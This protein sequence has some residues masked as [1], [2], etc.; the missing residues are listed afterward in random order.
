MFPLA[1]INHDTM[2]NT[3]TAL[4]KYA[5][6]YRRVSTEEQ[7][8]EGR[9]SLDTQ[10]RVCTKAVE[11]SEFEVAE[12][13]LYS[14]EGKSATT[15]NRPALQDLLL[16][17]GDDKSIGAVFVQ[18]TDRLARNA[19]DHLT[20]KLMFKK[21]G[22]QLVSVSQ[23]GLED[24]PEGNFMDLVIAGVNQFQS[25]I[26][27]RKS[28]KSMDERFRNGWYPT[29]AP[30]GYLNVPD[31]KNPDKKII[32]IDPVRGSLVKEMLTLYATGNHSLLEVRDFMYKKGLVNQIGNCLPRS[33]VAWIIDNPF[34]WGEMTWGG[35]TGIGKHEPLISKEL[36]KKCQAVKA[37]H[38]R[39]TC[40]RRKHN[41]L[42]NGYIYC[43]IC[44][45]RWTAEKHPRKDKS[46]YRC[47]AQPGVRCAEHYI[48]VDDL[49]E[50]IERKFAAIEFSPEFIEKIVARVQALYQKKKGEI[51]EKQVAL[52]ARKSNLLTKLETAEEKLISGILSD[53]DFVR[54]RAKTLPLIQAV[55][56][57]SAKLDRARNI[58][59]EVIQ[60]IL[61]LIRNLGGTYKDA[62][63]EIKR[64]YL[65]LFWSKFEVANR[66]VAEAIPSELVQLMIGI[67]AISINQTQRKLAPERMF[68]QK[69][70][71]LKENVRITTALLR[72]QDSNLQPTP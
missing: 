70:A 63:P 14:D 45:R 33:Q 55:D 42:L 30:I 35:M 11:D 20:I 60:K 31:P 13:A 64:L 12:N 34:Y 29:K 28:R 61:G 66:E 25:Q 4:K 22:V 62:T 21:H 71:Y 5:L 15:M 19:S 54:I 44:K 46:Y 48:D 18:D 36:H 32:V 26:T 16:R 43:A 8:G 59:I 68:A 50:E 65:G 49:E 69:S 39:F 67:G 52:V 47:N 6:I 3:P 24:T 72:E 51:T 9:Y 57:E 58:K 37:A 7:A 56:V 41:F 1:T 17:I 10:L 27:G 2:K 53:E 23:P 38:N 40:R